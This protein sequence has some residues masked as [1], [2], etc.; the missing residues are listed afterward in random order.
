MNYISKPFPSAPISLTCIQSPQ[1]NAPWK[2]PNQLWTRFYPFLGTSFL[3]STILSFFYWII[4]TSTHCCFKISY[5]KTFC[6]WSHIPL[7]Y[8]LVLCFSLYETPWKE[9]LYSLALL[10]ICHCLLNLL[11]RT[12]SLLHHEKWLTQPMSPSPPLPWPLSSIKHSGTRPSPYSISFIWFPGHHIP[13]I[14]LFHLCG[15]ASFECSLLVHHPLFKSQN[16]QVPKAWFA[17]Y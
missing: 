16:A 1:M 7:C 3:S 8:H 10:F 2:V 14:F 15:L 11:K 9:S 17:L 12:S 6:S 5:L 13:L 4:P